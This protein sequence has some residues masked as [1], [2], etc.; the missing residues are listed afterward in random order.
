MKGDGNQAAA[1]RKDLFRAHKPL[2]QLAVSG[3][4]RLERLELTRQPEKPKKE[5][6]D[7]DHHD[8]QRTQQNPEPPE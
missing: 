7:Q 8:A 2:D 1:G 4:V 6:A 5:A 3:K